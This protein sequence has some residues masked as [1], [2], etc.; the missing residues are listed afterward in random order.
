M[1]LSKSYILEYYEEIK[2]G[3][4]I[5]GHELMLQLEILVKELTDIEYQEANN[6]MVDYEASEKRIRFIETKCKHSEAPYAGKPFVLELFQKAF[7]EAI[8]AI[9]IYDD[10][11]NSI[12]SLL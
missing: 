3:N 2:A 8:F 12:T 7:I 6:I 5:V 11:C 10:E 9:K 1:T 4:I